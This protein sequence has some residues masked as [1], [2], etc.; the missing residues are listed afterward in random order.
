[1]L[2]LQPFKATPTTF[3]LHARVCTQ[4]ELNSDL[5]TKPNRHFCVLNFRKILNFKIL[6]CIFSIAVHMYTVWRGCSTH[7]PWSSRYSN[8]FQRKLKKKK[9]SI[10]SSYNQRSWLAVVSTHLFHL[11]YAQKSSLYIPNCRGRHWPSARIICCTPVPIFL[12][13]MFKKKCLTLL[14][15]PFQLL[16][17]P[18]LWEFVIWCQ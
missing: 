8:L 3:Q 5:K 11:F 18:K 4:V 7:G 13:G 17:L 9:D 10:F 6:K 14:R 12:D 2:M 16:L 1:M 15:E